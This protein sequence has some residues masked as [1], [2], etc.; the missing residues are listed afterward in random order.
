MTARDTGTWQSVAGRLTAALHLD[1]APIA[2]TFCAAAP[3]GRV[4]PFADPATPM[5]APSV[6]GRTGRVPAGCVFWVHALERT[7]ATRPEDHGNC[8]L[9]SLTHGLIDLA[10][11]STRA[12][13]GALVEAG[14]VTPEIFPAIPTVS[15]RA[16]AIV[17]GPLAD[18]TSE[19][20]VV[21][22]R[23]NARG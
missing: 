17:Y 19:P 12:D 7:F 21:L 22:V 20:D 5:P 23:T 6:D 10:T 18:A 4:P 1:V 9:G 8:S 11:A 13:V 16:E 3:S 14:W 2:I 15:S